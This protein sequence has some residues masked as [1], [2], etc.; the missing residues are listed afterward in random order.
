MWY[1]VDE[2]SRHYSAACS[3][4]NFWVVTKEATEFFLKFGQPTG[5][6]LMGVDESIEDHHHIW[7]VNEGVHYNAVCMW[8][9]GNQ[10]YPEDM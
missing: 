4:R 6:D 1:I 5:E 2:N 3:H 8:I 9:D 7:W 10:L